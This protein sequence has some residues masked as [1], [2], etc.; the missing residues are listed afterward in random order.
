MVRGRVTPEAAW[1]GKVVRIISGGQTG[2]DRAGLEAGRLLGVATGGTAPDNFLTEH[3]AFQLFCCCGV[4]WVLR[5]V[6]NSNECLV[7]RAGR[8]AEAFVR[9]GG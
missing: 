8:V 5:V 2:A 9:A 1:T 4:P 6:L 7:C 3:G